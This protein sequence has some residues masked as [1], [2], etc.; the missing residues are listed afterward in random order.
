VSEHWFIKDTDFHNRT[1]WKTLRWDP[2]WNGI[3]INGNSIDVL[4]HEFLTKY[5]YQFVKPVIEEEF[6]VNL[7]K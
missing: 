6:K 3:A 5:S 1:I 2:N 7:Q 4:S